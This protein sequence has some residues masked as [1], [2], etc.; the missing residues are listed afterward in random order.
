MLARETQ[1]ARPRRG[2]RTA[3]ALCAALMVWS[4]IAAPPTISQ[5]AEIQEPS[6]LAAYATYADAM[7]IQLYL[8]HQARQIPLGPAI[9]H[10]QSE[11]S[12]P[13]S[14][15]SIAWLVDGG[16]A[17][18]LHGTTTGA[19]VPTE[20][21]AKQPGGSSEEQFE[22]AGGPIGDEAFAVVHAGRAY[23]TAVHSDNPR[24]YSTSQLGNVLILPAAGSPPDAP[25][26]YD[27]NATFPGGDE[28]ETDPA[29][30]GQMG[31]LSIGSIASTAESIRDGSTV[32]SIAV[33]ELQ[34]VNIGN[35]TSDNR[36]ANCIRIDKVR[37]E[38]FTSTSGQ[39]GSAEAAYRVIIG[40]ACRR[41]FN[42]DTGEEEDRCLPLDPRD[43]Q[44]TDGLQH[45]EEIEQL[46]EFFSKP[47]WYEMTDGAVDYMVG[48]R[49]HAGSRHEDESR[50]RRTSEPPDDPERNYAA[51]RERG[52]STRAVAEA[53]DVEIWT[54]TL[55]QAYDDAERR[56]GDT[57]GGDL[58]DQID[59]DDEAPG[60]QVSGPGPLATQTGQQTIPIQTVRSIRR[61]HL[62]LGIARANSVARTLTGT[63]FDP[64]GGGGPGAAPTDGGLG[65]GAPAPDLGPGV[66][67]GVPGSTTTGLTGPFSLKF[68]W[69]SFRIRPW[70]PYDM[71]KGIFIAGMIA[72]LWWLAKRRLGS[73]VSPPSG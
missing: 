4:V 40:R 7:P 49:I 27:P 55:T 3:G 37:A 36:C 17:N 24:G 9:A 54:V 16:V 45:V 35:R 43:P 23:A 20:A 18:G 51:K 10:S 38:A 11:V 13:S 62:A 65:T 69:S 5:E 53:L 19:K 63:G 1:S 66:T 15:S 56:I 12:L 57:P 29:P 33:A 44:G 25:G 41:A 47:V 70:A 39:P 26:T 14:A 6:D 71:A 46:N 48:V 42:A 32:T 28:G 22:I 58:I 68:D 2:L 60:I 30:R 73:G 8:D 52:E 21:S 72:G 34:D 64:V 50:S 61:V 67:G 31:I 59:E